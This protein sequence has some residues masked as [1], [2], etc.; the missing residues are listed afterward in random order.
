M[1]NVAQLTGVRPGFHKGDR[2]RKAR[3]FA[4]LEQVELAQRIDVHRG[5]IARYE[6]GDVRVKLPVVIAWAMATGVDANWLLNGDDD[7]DSATVSDL[8]RPEGFEP[9]TYWSVAE[10]FAA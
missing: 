10:R 4:G 3:E 2:L 6:S 9:P 5:T 7:G 1:T 8:V